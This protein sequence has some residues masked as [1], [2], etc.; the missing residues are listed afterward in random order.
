MRGQLLTMN[1]PSP[2][3]PTII[4][5]DIASEDH[6]H[7]S[8]MP[9]PS[10]HSLVLAVS[11]PCTP[12][13][14]DIH[15]T[16]KRKNCLEE[17]EECQ[18]VCNSVV[19]LNS[20][21]IEP[22]SNNG[23]KN[24]QEHSQQDLHNITLNPTAGY[25]NEVKRKKANNDAGVTHSS[26]KG[27]DVQDK[28][29]EATDL[30]KMHR[31]SGSSVSAETKSPSSRVSL[32]RNKM[33]ECLYPGCGKAYAKPS[34][35]AEH[36]RIHTDERPYK[37]YQ[38]DCNASFGREDHLAIH[39][40]GHGSKREFKCN[41]KGCTKAYYT[42]DKLS[43]HLKSHEEIA[44]LSA[45]NSTTSQSP[46]LLQST[47]TSDLS[48]AP[49]IGSDQGQEYTK[50]A[51]VNTIDLQ[52]IAEEIIK[53]KP[54]ACTWE[55]CIK[56]FT[57][58]QKLKAHICMIHEGRK[59]YPC[60]HEG[61]EMSFQTPS[62]LRK[63]Q[64]IHSGTSSSRKIEAAR[65]LAT[66]IK[67]VHEKISDAPRFKCEYEGCGIGFEFKHVLMKHIQR[68]HENPQPRK[69]RCDAIEYSV[70]D[71]LLGF[72]DSDAAKKLPF[73][74][75]FPGCEMRYSKERLLRKHM[76]S[77]AHRTGRITG[78]DFLRT[79]DEVESQTIQHLIELNL[80]AH[81]TEGGSQKEG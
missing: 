9:S 64:L 69:K 54:Y 37:C 50:Q 76:K 46:L 27:S 63:H 80:Q 15:E 18:D 3:T 48:S 22:T 70:L 11:A 47:A 62:K 53:E 43:R 21:N 38:E 24:P 42:K 71:D 56:R 57:K 79:M 26:Y 49:Y 40:K 78:T 17:E 65:T 30:D 20:T 33:Y 45:D 7:S 59:P 75:T 55:G 1:P 36:E 19:I 6:N 51:P 12:T 73:A 58:H 34:R 13:P 44:S 41:Q 72:T 32:S 74:C 68:K 52:K 66:H 16:K 8:E 23:N 31:D 61:C 28:A 35:L 67:T 39:I 77:S 5:Q 10:V 4:Q 60:T 81:S 25:R 14:H 29:V 2:P